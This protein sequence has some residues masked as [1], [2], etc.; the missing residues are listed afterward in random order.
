[1]S[2]DIRE[3]VTKA[4]D[5]AAE[6]APANESK[7][8]PSADV[9]P[10]TTP[11]VKTEVTP[12]EKEEDK[13]GA[14]E[15]P[16]EKGGSDK[17][18]DITKAFTQIENLNKALAEERERNKIK[19]R[20][21]EETKWIMEKMKNVFSPEPEPEAQEEPKYMTPEEVE[22]WYQQKEE[23]KKKQEEDQTYRQTIKSEIDT[24]TSEWNG[25]N[26]KPKYDDEEI[27]KWQTDN[28]K[29]YLSPKEAFNVMKSDEIAN[30]K[31]KQIINW[32][33]Q[34]TWQEQ[35]SW[36]SAEHTPSKTT[37]KTPAELKAAIFEA[38]SQPEM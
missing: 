27:F 18:V 31:A 4:M 13:G 2:E 11:E 21:L 33:A 6:S 8:V 17:E 10:E 15:R 32:Q 34:P 12:V 29:L 19:E 25:E 9:K 23:E 38:L 5:W 3:Q 35:P 14:T 20:E 22:A 26:W 16:V 30:W 37:P 28:N 24:L 36:V 1:M 7:D